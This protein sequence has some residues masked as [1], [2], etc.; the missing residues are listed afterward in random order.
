LFLASVAIIAELK[1]YRQDIRYTHTNMWKVLLCAV[2]Q[3]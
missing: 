2:Q 1:D 3:L